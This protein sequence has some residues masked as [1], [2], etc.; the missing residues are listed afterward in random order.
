MAVAV[1]MAGKALDQF[2]AIAI[3][4]ATATAIA[5]RHRSPPSLTA[6]AVLREQ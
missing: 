1:A 5:H 4:T 6:I 3:P 2:P